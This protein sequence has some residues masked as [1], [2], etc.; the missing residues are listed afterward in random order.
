MRAPPSPH[1]R[2]IAFR[3]ALLIGVL[4]V[5]VVAFVAVR[6]LSAQPGLPAGIVDLSHYRNNAGVAGAGS[7]AAINFDG[8]GHGYRSNDLAA[9]GFVAG[10][11]VTVHG[12]VFQWP[13]ASSGGWD[14]VVADGQIIT[15]PTRVAGKTLAF[16]GAATDGLSAGIGE[17][18]YADGAT[19]R[20]SLIESDWTL[21]R[22]TSVPSPENGVAAALPCDNAHACRAPRDYLF[23]QR[24]PLRWGKAI[25]A[26]RLP[27][28]TNRGRLHV[29]ALSVGN[30]SDLF[31]SAGYRDAQW[32]GTNLS[33]AEFQDQIEPGTY[34]T[35]YAFPITQTIS[36]F[37]TKGLRVLR[38]PVRWE[39]IQDGLGGPLDGANMRR[40][41]TLITYAA[42]H[43]A[44][45]IVDLHNYG[46]YV[47]HGARYLIGGAHVPQSALV[48]VWKKLAAHYV[49][50]PGIYGY[51]LMNEPAEGTWPHDAAAVIN[52]IRQVDTTTQ[53]LVESD[54]VG[55]PPRFTVTD[56][57]SNLFY[58][59]HEY[60]DRTGSGFY[61]PV[62]TYD[63]NGAY[64][65]IGID[66]ARPV[67][68]WLHAH[69]AKAFYGEYGIP[70][71]DPRWLT[72]LDNF[73]RYLHA[74][75]DVIAGG[76]YW[77]AGQRWNSYALSV[78][79]LNLGQ[80]AQT[81]AA[82]M[83]VLRKYPT[84]MRPSVRGEQ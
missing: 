13:A 79:P 56:P 66:R 57:M 54:I 74:N 69:H 14:N 9:R 58:S 77:S 11:L 45:V 8:R 84:R 22:D 7:A 3:F 31:A 35:D 51:D 15:P 16:L 80:P 43:D 36:Y 67:I 21:N 65:T 30:A 46:S 29:F 33:G 55:R 19:Q 68:T 20:F 83:G 5:A 10:Q 34:G 70:N 6:L 12:I 39:R 25:A 42:A 41:D 78:E 60:F 48:D 72:T 40:L 52:G 82:Q 2:R 63:M 18:R 53:L 50:N 64:P 27:V 37:V 62:Y 49:G 23:S 24:V 59:I 38:V 1:A 4:T 32:W 81:D 47:L 75:S 61:N 17:I 76:T 71:T 44:K 28:M 73:L 26:I